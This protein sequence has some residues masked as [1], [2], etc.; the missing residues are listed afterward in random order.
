MIVT[1]IN[2][3]CAA[4]GKTDEVLEFLKSLIPYILS[5][6][7]CLACEV[8]QHSGEK[9]HFVVLEKWESIEW[10]KKSIENFPKEKISA[11]MAL[12]AEAP[13]GDYYY[14]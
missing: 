13:E 11:A 6:K 4:P 12:F 3:F 8:L 14:G 2:K 1:R 9:N 5:S 7:G 10:H